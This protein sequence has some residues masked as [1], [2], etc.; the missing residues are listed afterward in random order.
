MLIAVLSG[1]AA[2]LAAPWFYKIARGAAG[3]LIAL[4]PLGLMI[5]FARF[6]EPVAAGQVIVISH[7]WVPSLG[8]K[9]SFLID[10]LSLL[11]AFLISGIGA[12]I[13]IYAGDYL[14]GHPQLGRFYAYIL[15]FM[16]SMLGLVLADNLIAVYV[17]WELTSISSYFLIGFDHNREPARAAALQA[18]LVTGAGGLALLAGVLLLGQAGGSLEISTLLK[19]GDMI[20]SNAL[21]V[22]ILL[23]VFAGAFTKSAQVPFHFWLPS[24]MEA[25]TPVSAYLHSATMVKA[26]V[27]LVAR[28][29][30]VLGDT[31][32]WIQA[33]TTVGGLTMIAGAYLALR[34]TDLKR[35]LAYL[36]VSALGMLI[37]FVGVGT[38]QAVAAAIVFLLAH[39]LYKGALFLVTGI[40][41]H[42][43]GSRDVKELGGLRSTMPITATIAVLAALSLAA[44]PPTLGFIGKEML[45]EALIAANRAGL[46]IAVVFASIIFVTTA[47]IIGIQPFFGKKLP[48]PKPPH[49][50]QAGLWSAPAILAVLGVIFAALPALVQGSLFQ[51]AVEAIVREPITLNVAVWHG[52]N[53]PLALS[54]VSLLFGLA[55]YA[56]RTPV[57]GILARLQI[58]SW[59]GPQ[60]W[61]R[62][63]LAGLNSLAERQTQLLQSGYLRY[64]LIIIILTSLTLAGSKLFIALD[65]AS[66]TANFDA[67]F[68]EWLIAGLILLAALAAVAT[69]S[70]LAAV[71]ALGVVGYGV[72]LVFVFF[73]APDLAITQFMIETLTVILFVLV[74]HH[75]P[76]FAILS[77]R[78]A[79]V[80]DAFLTLAV[81]ALITTIVLIG[82]GI[83]LYPKI[84][85]Y[86]IE[87]SLSL[88]H[89]R[90]VVNV[91]LVDF[92][93]F[94]TFG[95]ITVLAVAG[96]G[97]Y[98]LLK[99]KP[100]KK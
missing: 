84:S 37:V 35:M 93:G 98:A 76:R 80:R 4:L 52:F 25:P 90:N 21:Y 5:Y 55:I 85:T 71:A 6:V 65:T 40:V 22:P 54:A 10:G 27:Y 72:A 39:A 62:L 46:I 82:S 64:Y 47:G 15:I 57:I 79:R 30:P 41:D 51:P 92:R 67:R 60:D 68:H 61:Y 20:R 77:S 48:T 66:F 86:F 53:V 100:Q 2:S 97:V 32:I 43:T 88:A 49:E 89:G 11:F 95:E 36:T 42:Q 81:G 78:F 26:G 50:A 94:D 16:A 75:L 38:S 7:N 24:A 23:L 3:W 29:S 87:N 28:L 13:F 45:L 9:L 33:L 34:Q 96:I 56:R 8:I 12:L 31:E 44:L 1:F 99:L 74:F 69:R 58:S 18:L 83:Q 59:W 70:R 63:T 19:N 14:H 91:I 17:F 73:G